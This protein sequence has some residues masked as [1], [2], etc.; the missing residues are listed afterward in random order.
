MSRAAS[1]RMIL[2]LVLP[3]TSVLLAGCLEVEQHPIWRAGQYDG[4][5]DDRHAARNFH[6]DRL[7]WHATIINRNLRQDE[8]NR[9]RDAQERVDV[10][11]KK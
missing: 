6:N 8:Y 5:P 1:M 2:L 4:K 3:A 7:A 11:D 9:T 10:I